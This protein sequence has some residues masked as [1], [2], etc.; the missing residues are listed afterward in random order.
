MLENPLTARLV[1]L[2]QLRDR[3]TELLPVD[4]EKAAAAMAEYTR[5]MV[6]QWEREQI[7]R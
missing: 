2:G 7:G 3:A 1:E 6:E 4:R 5:E